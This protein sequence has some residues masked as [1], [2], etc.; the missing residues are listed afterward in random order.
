MNI[1]EHLL[2]TESHEWV[3]L[4]ENGNARVGITDH[5]QQAMGDLVYVELPQEEDVFSAG[6]GM[7]V[8]ES[9]KAVSDVY[10][11]V[12]G[13]VAAVNEGLL[14]NPALINEA[15]YDAWMVELAQVEQTEL[16]TPA[17]YAELLKT[18]EEE[19]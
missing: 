9:V 4:L 6:D 16:L 13:V 7:A 17:Q 10:A 3:E 5:A 8:V 1:P 14:D 15:A 19:A 11:P 2:Y 12:G 18:L